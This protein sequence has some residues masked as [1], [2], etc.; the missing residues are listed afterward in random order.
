MV[1][2]Q[3]GLYALL[4]SVGELSLFIYNLIIE[5]RPLLFIII[6]MGAIALSFQ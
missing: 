1:L 6:D 5:E 2:K 3:V 4:V